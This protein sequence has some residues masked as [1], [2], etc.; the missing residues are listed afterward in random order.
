ML[1]CVVNF[2]H[3][4]NRSLCMGNERFHVA[5]AV[6]NFQKNCSILSGV[7]LICETLCVQVYHSA[8]IED[9]ILIE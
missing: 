1:S 5:I 4:G 6:H 9:N 7:N 3:S 2:K 8:D